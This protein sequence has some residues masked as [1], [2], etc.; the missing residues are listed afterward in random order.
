MILRRFA[1][2]LAAQVTRPLW[3]LLHFALLARMLGSEGFGIFVSLYALGNTLAAFTDLGQHQTAFGAIRQAKDD[4]A[5]SSVSWTAWRV[6]LTG[7]TISILGGIIV[8]ASGLAPASIAVAIC[9]LAVVSPLGDVS[10][11]LLRG[12]N[13][14]HYEVIVANAE[15]AAIF[16]LLLAAG[17]AGRVAPLNAL[18]CYVFIGLVRMTVTD[19]MRRRIIPAKPGN[20]SRTLFREV[21]ASSPVAISVLAA[22]GYSRLPLFIFPNSLDPTYFA[23]FAGFWT[24]FQR[25]QIVLNALIQTGFRSG[26]TLW[27]GFFSSA[28]WLT[29][30]G[31][32]YGAVV[33]TIA[34]PLAPFLTRLYLGE[35]Y[36]DSAQA[37]T[38]ATLLTVPSYAIF[39]IRSALQY[40]GRG[41]LV[42]LAFMLAFIVAILGH[43]LLEPDHFWIFAPYALSSI[44]C[45]IVLVST[46]EN[47]NFVCREIRST[48]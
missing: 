43:L 18:W 7:S 16:V 31:L 30:I 42:T 24:L 23:V 9:L 48:W 36:L 41:W 47:L 40:V 39:L 21:A 38:I 19:V 45:L 44:F 22:S 10:I 5:R 26:D 17:Q 8:A 3:V 13:K 27:E 6:K 20:D 33:C 11:A 28:R 46:S 12:A 1:F 15:Q 35:S 34:I 29:L 37:V 4:K 14:P 32:G 2:F 25:G